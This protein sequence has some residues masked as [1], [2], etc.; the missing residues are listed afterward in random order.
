MS[1]ALL[2]E[3]IVVALLAMIPVRR[4]HAAGWASGTLFTAWVLYA[5]GLLVGVRFPGAFRFLVPVIAVAFVAPFVVRPERLTWLF[6]PRR[7]A[8]RPILDVTPPDPPGLPGPDGQA[9]GPR[10]PRG[11]RLGRRG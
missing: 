8:P 3:L 2:A 7:A 6:G 9:A 11:P 4:L 1:P 5:V 10:R